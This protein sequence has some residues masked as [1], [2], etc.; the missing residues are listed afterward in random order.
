VRKRG[1]KENQERDRE[2]AK[3]PWKGH[4]FGEGKR[5]NRVDSCRRKEEGECACLF[6]SLLLLKR[7]S[8][9]REKNFQHILADMKSL[10]D[11][12]V[13]WRARARDSQREDHSR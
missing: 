5:T 10:S 3:I 4:S 12:R 1:K 8:V 7:A 6:D 13:G 11:V 2:T 9:L